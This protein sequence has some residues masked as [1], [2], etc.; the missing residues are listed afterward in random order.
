MVGA[1]V[2]PVASDADDDDD[3]GRG[4]RRGDGHADPAGDGGGDGEVD[5]AAHGDGDEQRPGGPLNG[6]GVRHS[7]RWASRCG[8]A[9]P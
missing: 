9:R 1:P 5:A 6:P 2:C 4:Q 7:R 8:T 3:G